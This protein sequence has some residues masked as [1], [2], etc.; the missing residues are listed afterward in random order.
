[1]DGDVAGFSLFPASV[2]A[3]EDSTTSRSSI[4]VSPLHDSTTMSSIAKVVEMVSP[5]S[6]TNDNNDNGSIW[7]TPTLPKMTQPTT[8]EKSFPPLPNLS[9]SSPPIQEK[10]PPHSRKRQRN[11]SSNC[12]DNVGRGIWSY[13]LQDADNSDNINNIATSGDEIAWKIISVVLRG[14]CIIWVLFA[15]LIISAEL[16]SS[17][18]NSGSNHD[19]STKNIVIK[20]EDE[21][22]FL[23]IAENVTSKCAYDNL[24][25]EI[26]RE[27]CQQLCFNRMCCFIDGS[28]ANAQFEVHT[29]SCA[30]DPNKMCAAYAGCESLVVAEDDA[31]VYNANGIDVFGKKKNTTDE[32]MTNNMVSSQEEQSQSVTNTTTTTTTSELQL[33]QQVITSVCHKDNLHSRHG[34]NECASLCNPSICCFNRTE[35]EILNPRFDLKLK[36]EGI[37]N[38][39]LDRSV[40]GTCIHEN[41]EGVGHRASIHNHFC[42]VHEGCQNVLLLGAP[43]MSIL[44]KNRQ[45]YQYH[46]GGQSSAEDEEILIN[47]NDGMIANGINGSNESS[48]ITNDQE[49][50]LG[51]VFALLG[52][53]VCIS[54]YLLVHQRKPSENT[55]QL[56]MTSGREETIEF[57]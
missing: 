18:S 33:V 52:I 15:I 7:T 24:N 16:F 31:I 23:E 11:K 46:K 13:P 20:I 6:P 50:M 54:V 36:M 35:I 49:R 4:N 12:I 56:E 8:E 27:E 47:Y 5:S 42:N 19:V 2:R 26:G 45:K 39:I 14:W 55:T 21:Q 17:S 38:D 22:T 1:M 25:T 29:Y 44:E 3:D 40:M 41:D 48:S 28:D 9:S 51:T 30:N 37:S 43:P 34:I 57:V 32:S 53:M 10:N